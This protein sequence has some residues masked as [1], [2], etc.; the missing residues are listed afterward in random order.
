MALLY[1]FKNCECLLIC[2]K[3]SSRKNL[4]NAPCFIGGFSFHIQGISDFQCLLSIYTHEPFLNYQ[5]VQCICWVRFCMTKLKMLARHFHTEVKYSVFVLLKIWGEFRH[6]KTSNNVLVW[7]TSA[8]GGIN[9][10]NILNDINIICGVMVELSGIEPLTSWMPFKRSP[11]WAIAPHS[12][13]QTLWWKE[14]VGYHVWEESV[15]FFLI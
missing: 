2:L 14:V 6:K 15:K 9:Y 12:H 3:V 11:S 7:C 13:L 4:S 1:I 5:D 8:I 10:E